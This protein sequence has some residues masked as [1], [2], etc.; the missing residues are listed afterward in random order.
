MWSGILLAVVLMALAICSVLQWRFVRDGCNPTKKPTS[1]V[2]A[3]ERLVRLIY[4]LSLLSVWMNSGSRRF[5]S[6]I[7]R[8][9]VTVVTHAN[10]VWVWRWLRCSVMST[11]GAALVVIGIMWC[12]R[13]C[14]V[15]LEKIHL[16]GLLDV[17][18]SVW[19]WRCP[20][21]VSWGSFESWG[22]QLSVHLPCIGCGGVRRCNGIKSTCLWC[23]GKIDS[24]WLWNQGFL[25]RLM[26]WG[27][28]QG[29]VKVWWYDGFDCGCNPISCHG[30][31]SIVAIKRYVGDPTED[32]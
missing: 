9:V 12:G 7:V 28:R 5:N 11:K 10:L 20:Y 31:G 3:V 32:F 19:G 15:N 13:L 8:V 30:G 6:S 2:S 21:C 14:N 22:G 23:T 1:T 24:S 4:T 16:E 27:R 26:R 29:G 25:S 17:I 18:Q